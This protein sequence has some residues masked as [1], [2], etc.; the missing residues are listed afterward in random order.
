MLEEEKKMLKS[1]ASLL[2]LIGGF[3]RDVQSSSMNWGVSEIAGRAFEIAKDLERVEYVVYVSRSAWLFR[4]L[5]LAEE[6]IAYSQET[7]DRPPLP[8]GR[9]QDS[10]ESARQIEQAV[11]KCDVDTRARD[12]RDGLLSLHVLRSIS[13][14]YRLHAKK[15]FTIHD[16]AELKE[17]IENVAFI[18]VIPDGKFPKKSKVPGDCG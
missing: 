3:G 12:A 7:T 14:K 10:Y 6:E 5:R 16:A 17:F 8:G 1:F 11:Y 9:G 2:D 13:E 18:L 4:L 15:R